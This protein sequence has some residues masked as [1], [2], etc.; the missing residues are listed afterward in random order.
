MLN[1]KVH[2]KELGHFGKQLSGDILYS[3]AREFE[4]Y[5]LFLLSEVNHRLNLLMLYRY[6]FS[7]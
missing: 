3:G 7:Y 4:R 5:L 6:S 1:Y 2:F